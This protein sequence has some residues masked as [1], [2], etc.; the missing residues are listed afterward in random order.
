MI[1]NVVKIVLRGLGGVGKTSLFEVFQGRCCPS[2]HKPSQQISTTNVLWTNPL[3]KERVTVLLYIQYLMSRL[4]FGM[5]LIKQE[6]KQWIR[7]L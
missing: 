7:L 1:I 6:L 2:D 3:T 4:R 5:L